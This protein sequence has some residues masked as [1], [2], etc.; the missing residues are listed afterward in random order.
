[1]PTVNN[2]GRLFLGSSLG[3]TRERQLKR[4]AGVSGVRF[5]SVG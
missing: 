1:M 5:V 2:R 3:W 4:N